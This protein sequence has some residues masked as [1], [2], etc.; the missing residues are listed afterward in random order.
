MFCG[1]GCVVGN[2]RLGGIHSNSASVSIAGHSPRTR[3]F[4][5]IGVAPNLSRPP[6]YQVESANKRTPVGLPFDASNW[7]LA[8][9]HATEAEDGLPR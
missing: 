4:R 8:M 6:S 5:A 2:R 1:C 3:D 9:T 7:S